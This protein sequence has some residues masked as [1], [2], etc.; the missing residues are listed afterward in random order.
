M[1]STINTAV[2]AIAPYSVNLPETDLAT[3]GAM[4]AAMININM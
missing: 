1:V 2:S 4:V 3:L